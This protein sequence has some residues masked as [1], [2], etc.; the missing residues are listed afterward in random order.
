MVYLYILPQI[1]DYVKF[2]TTNIF[3]KHAL[4]FDQ[5]SLFKNPDIKI[6]VSQTLKIQEVREIIKFIHLKPQHKRKV[7]VLG[8][9]DYATVEA[10]NA[11]LKLLED[12]PEYACMLL[13]THNTHKVLDTIKSRCQIIDIRKAGLVTQKPEKNTFV[14]QLVNLQNN[15]KRF[16]FIEQR[17]DISKEDVLM[18]IRVIH[19]A[20]EKLTDP[21]QK[22]K[23]LYDIKLLEQGISLNTGIKAIAKQAVLLLD[24]YP[25]IEK[26]L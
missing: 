12:K 17:K 16:S 19:K 5:D 3:P 14:S 22:L 18:L 24:R 25:F 2:F 11:L 26:F 10:Q 23:I 9:M 8:P 1:N 4:T 7:L 6:H 21:K 15:L 20:V 13:F